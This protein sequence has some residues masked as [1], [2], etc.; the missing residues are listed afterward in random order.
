M[1][2][3][4]LLWLIA[5][6]IATAV[7]GWNGA[8]F[9]AT[10]QQT[11]TKDLDFLPPPVVAQA[12]S[13]GQQSALAKLRWIDSFAYFQLQLDRQD[14]RVAGAD[15]RGGFERLYEALIAMDPWFL[16]FYEHAVLN[17][18]G[19]MRQQ[20]V[21]LSFIMRGLSSMPRETALWRMA[22][23]ELAVSFGLT[24]RLPA[25]LDRW[26]NAWSDHEDDAD[27]R[28][29]VL[30]WRRG[31]A[32]ANSEGLETLPYWLEHLRATKPGTPVAEYVESTLRVLL[33][34]HGAKELEMVCGALVLPSRVNPIMAPALLPGGRL[35]PDR[36]L[37]AIRW[38]R[39]APPWSA[40]RWDG[41]ELAVRCDPF[42][43]EWIWSG[44]R[45][46]SPGREHM[47]F[48]QRVSAVRQALEAEANARGRSPRDAAEAAAWGV[49][50]PDPPF[51]GRWSFA[52]RLPEVVWPEPPHQ[53]WPLR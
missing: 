31:L 33:A 52:N 34:D 19:V 46:V 45:I 36:R 15:R 23:A 42:G 30:D 4:L 7:I 47:R 32:F 21:A 20:Q 2:G 39:Q 16:P 28:Q 13:L 9:M 14:D 50:L 49:E 26:L 37:V 41:T 8:R 29:R 51:G 38:P 27:G 53:A 11:R 22:S 1:R 48:V 12:L 5:G 17:T 6:G 10:R 18:G 35:R 25:V 24:K 3:N 43:Y 40:V 44:G